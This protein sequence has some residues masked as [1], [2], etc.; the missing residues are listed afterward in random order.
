MAERQFWDGTGDA[1]GKV[2]FTK[3]NG[4]IVG[5]PYVRSRV[6]RYLSQSLQGD[7]ARRLYGDNGALVVL[8]ILSVT[9]DND[10][11]LASRHQC[12]VSYV[13]KDAAR[14]AFRQSLDQP[15]PAEESDET[16]APLTLSDIKWPE[17]LNELYA[18]CDANRRDF[19]HRNGWAR[20]REICGTDADRSTARLRDLMAQG[21]IEGE[22]CGDSPQSQWCWRVTESGYHAVKQYRAAFE[23]RSAE[24]TPATVP[25]QAR[26]RPRP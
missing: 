21:L 26:R 19:P 18:A 11:W 24:G 12:L 13:C 7:L 16:K 23:A 2:H 8:R 1:D 4:E 25:P 6:S 10:A 3:N 15:N 20:T 9:V 17:T 14:E 5:R 22:K